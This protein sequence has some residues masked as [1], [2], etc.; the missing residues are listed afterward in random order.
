MSNAFSI[1]GVPNLTAEQVVEVDRAMIEDYL[2]EL[3]QMMENRGVTLSIWPERAFSMG[4]AR[5]AGR[6]A[7]LLKREHS[8][9]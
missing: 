6:R 1:S 7:R 4:P 2:I 3:I 8:A 5:S 9:R